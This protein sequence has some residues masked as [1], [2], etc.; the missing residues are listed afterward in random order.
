MKLRHRHHGPRTRRGARVTPGTG[1]IVDLFAG[2][3]GA[4][5][6]ISAAL[7]REPDV[8]LNHDELAMRVHEDN[9]PH[10]EHRPEDVWKTRP[11]EVT[12]KKKVYL[13]WASPDCTHFSRAKGGKPKEKKIRALA[14][15][16]TRWADDVRPSI[17]MVENVREFLEW[18]PLHE[19]GEL[20]GMPI[21][22]R[23]GEYFNQ[24]RG[25]L[26]LLGY[27]VE[28]RLLTACDFGAPTSRTR[29][30]IVA[31]CDGKPICW[32]EPTHGPGRP[33]G[34]RT[35]AECIDWDRPC[36][37]IFLTKDEGRALGVKRPLAP[38]TMQRIFEG[39]RRYV[40]ENPT[41]FIVGVGGRAGQTPPT[42]VDAPVGTITAKNDRA[43][44]VP[45]IV[46]VNHGGNEH[47]T[48][49]I[50]E[51]LTTVTAQRRGHAVVAAFLARHYGDRGQRPGL[52]MT[53]PVA[54]ITAQDHHSLIEM[55]LEER[56]GIHEGGAEADRVWGDRG[57]ARR[58]DLE[59]EEPERDAAHF[60]EE[61]GDEEQARIPDGARQSS[62]QGVSSGRAP[63]GLDG[64][65]RTHPGGHGHQPQGWDTNEQ[66][67]GQHRGGD[68]RREPP[69]RLPEAGSEAIPDS[70]GTSSRGD[71][72]GS[73]GSSGQ[74]FVVRR[75]RAA[76][77]HLPDGCIHGRDRTEEVR[78]FLI[79]Y[80]SSGG[81]AAPVDEPM[82][83]ITALAR[84]GLVTVYGS[85]YQIVD[86]GMRMLEPDELKRAQ[87]GK[88]AEAYDLSSA[89]TKRDQVRLIGN[90]VCP[91]V[92]EALVR[93]NAGEDAAE[94]PAA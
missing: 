14:H 48:E 8:A 91:E 23:K 47:R 42:G 30:F 33:L 79:Q 53:E 31:R 27:T 58:D 92:A 50:D 68:T 72:A 3:G 40:V 49:P 85:L 84:M 26:E 12:R 89:T 46:K 15:V 66:P 1:L 57:P 59:A 69:A 77:E 78:A 82:R 29:L 41:P 6:G 60:T 32:P 24:W 74:G 43:L 54:T 45:N 63:I 88:Y 16:V 39:V 18:G 20:T 21:H 37:S 44:V 7:G 76:P 62:R 35:A 34:Y 75:D 73:A 51:P 70:E 28:F 38:K 65:A 22:E 36:P 5:C 4:S 2:C 86:I 80:Y 93:A 17:I 9:H 56:H 67:P 81:Q 55:A 90:S 61:T 19:T 83:T 25:S 11:R 64:A 94:R 10:T 52:E 71:Q 87:F 13:L